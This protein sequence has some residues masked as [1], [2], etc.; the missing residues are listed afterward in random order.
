MC[1][2]V[3]T[4]NTSVSSAG[5]RKFSIIDETALTRN[6]VSGSS[7]GQGNQARSLLGTISEF[8]VYG[9]GFPKRA[10]YRSKI[11]D[12]G[13]EQNFGRLFFT[14]T[15]MRFVDGEAVE[16]PD[17]RAFAEVEVRTGRDDDPNI[18]Q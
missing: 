17:A 2:L 7:G 6:R 18:Y 12:L 8:E 5:P 9:E 10:T 13:T 16:A 15:P 1:G 4:N 14:A 11:I 3:S